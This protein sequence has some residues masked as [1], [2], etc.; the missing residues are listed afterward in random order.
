LRSGQLI[1]DQV[2]LYNC[3]QRNT[4]KAAIRFEGSNTKEQ[5]ISNT[6]VHEG[7]GL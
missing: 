4:L 6:V 3:S 2:E 1:L 7:W 5:L